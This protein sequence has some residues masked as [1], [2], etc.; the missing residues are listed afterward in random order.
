MN[1]A[2]GWLAVVVTIRVFRGTLSECAMDVQYSSNSGS[3]G[4]ST[5]RNAH[6][7]KGK[8]LQ[9][10]VFHALL[11]RVPV[12]LSILVFSAASD[13]SSQENIDYEYDDL[14]RLTRV[15]R[16]SQS[17]SVRYHYDEV[18][19]LEWIAGDESP[20]S[21]GDDIPN[22]ADSDD[23]NDG[24]PDAVEIAAGLDALDSV[25]LMGALGDFDNDGITNI[26]EYLQGS[27]INHFH[28][29]L[30]SDSDVDL[31]DLIVLKR[32]ILGQQDATQE[33]GE[34][35]HGD[36]NMDGYLDVGDLVILKRL[37]LE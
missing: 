36:V 6:N 4:L 15:V 23:D 22:F 1:A 8:C 33:Q 30:D 35:G 12:M 32:I 20:D 7:Q 25:G 9:G 14:N 31:G 16:E 10:T 28:G 13:G 26:D 19:N 2:G 17:A 29:D 11:M 3:T 27:D 18:S 34:S 37:Y 24:I 5:V 21:D